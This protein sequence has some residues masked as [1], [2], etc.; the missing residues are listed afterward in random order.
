MKETIAK[1]VIRK[2]MSSIVHL[3]SHIYLSNLNP[4]SFFLPQKKK[5]KKKS[6]IDESDF[7]V[8]EEEDSQQTNS[9][10]SPKATTF[11]AKKLTLTKQLMAIPCSLVTSTGLLK[12][13]LDITT[14]SVIFTPIPEE[15]CLYK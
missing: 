7:L 10:D 5:K 2:F 11:Q 9:L 8:D 13:K 14:D 4:L 15:Y 12:G 1:K 3:Y 6:E